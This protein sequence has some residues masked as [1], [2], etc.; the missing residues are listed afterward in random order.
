MSSTLRTTI[1]DLAATFATSVLDALRGS[2][3]EEILA[4]SRGGA[5]SAVPVRRGPG[6]PRSIAVAETI[7]RKPVIASGIRRKGG[8][9]SRRSQDDISALVDRIVD[10]LADSPD[11]LRAEQ[12]RESLSLEAK[13]LPRPLNDALRAKRIAKQGQKRATTY[14]VRGA[15]GAKAA[16]GRAAKSN[17]ASKSARKAK[18][19]P[20]PGKRGGK[21]RRSAKA[22][23]EGSNANENVG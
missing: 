16:G 23:G 11:G 2:S 1:S 9:L 4:E 7:E 22:E 18:P 12:I 13:E 8:R 21:G 10:L 3:L 6:R 20:K 15:G 14:F 17:G 19:G 5:S